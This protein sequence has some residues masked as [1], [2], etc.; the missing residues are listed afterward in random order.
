MQ[1]EYT[2]TRQLLLLTRKLRMK[3]EERV[4]KCERWFSILMTVIRLHQE[5]L[6][7]VIRM[8]N[9]RSHFNTLSSGFIL[10]FRVNKSS[11]RRVVV[12]SFCIAL[13]Q[14]DIAELLTCGFYES[15]LMNT[16]LVSSDS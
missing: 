1:N 16:F 10:S 3:P 5:N 13:D 11:M 14:I 6:I 7:T 4:L 8:E 2:T 15:L 12:Y 9:Q